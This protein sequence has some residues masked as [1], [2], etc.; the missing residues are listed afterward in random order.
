MYPFLYVF[1]IKLLRLL[2]S[3]INNI[4]DYIVKTDILLLKYIDKCYTFKLLL[5]SQKAEFVIISTFC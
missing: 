3:K 2:Y 4:S 1:Y 5:K